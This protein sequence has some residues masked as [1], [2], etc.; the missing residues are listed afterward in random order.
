MTKNSY[1]HGNLRH[2]LIEAGIALINQD[3]LKQFSLRK[4]A[5]QCGVSHAAPYSHF[6]DVDQLLN[7]MGEHVTQQFT[8]QLQSS[9]E[10]YENS[11]GA[12]MRLGRAYIQFFIDH[13]QYFQFLFYVS[14][15]TVDVDR[16]TP[17]E[18]PPFALFRTATLQMLTRANIP[19]ENQTQILLGMWAM[20]HGISALLTNSGIQYN[21]DWQQVFMT[22]LAMKEQKKEQ[23]DEDDPA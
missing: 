23:S 3:G 22:M 2:Q 19:K 9:M 14:P 20:V 5:A 21:G 12:T 6:K 4:V 13:P 16:S 10:G 11:P 1:H 18:Y 15:I 8:Q 7:A 17:D